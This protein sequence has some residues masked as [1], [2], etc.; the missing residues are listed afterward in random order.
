MGRHHFPDVTACGT[1]TAVSLPCMFSFLVQADYSREG[2]LSQETLL[3]VLVRAGFDLC[4]ADNNTGDQRIAARTGWTMVEASLDPLACAAECSDA[5][6]LPLI[7]Q[8][9]ASIDTDTV[10]VLHMISNHGPAYYLRYDKAHT[11]FRP[12]CRAARFA[13]CTVDEIV[14]AYGKAA[15][16][17]DHVLS[18][19][20]DLLA[21]SERV[22][23]AMVFLSDNGESLGENGLYLHAAPRFM[24]PDAQL[25]AR[26]VMWPGD[27]FRAASGLDAGCLH[28]VARRTA[29]HDNLFHTVLGL[30]DVEAGASNPALDL[31]Q[32]CRSGVTGCCAVSLKR[33][34]RPCPRA[35]VFYM[36]SMP[37]AIPTPGLSCASANAC[38]RRSAHEY[39]RA[40]CTVS[41]NV[42]SLAPT[43]WS[44]PSFPARRAGREWH[45]GSTGIAPV[46]PFIHD[47]RRGHRS[48]SVKMS[49]VP[50]CQYLAWMLE[51]VFGVLARPHRRRQARSSNRHETRG[52]R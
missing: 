17:T 15:L 46:S 41:I 29:S 26:L 16:E 43:E 14:N 10:L 9:L 6:F 35:T 51:D 52:R 24:A 3:D 22:L 25:K 38:Q 49:L 48:H 33:L 40:M 36:S 42:C 19:A 31:T 18:R 39:G 5:V 11:R 20:I 21:A 37:P 1:S 2:F 8:T 30:A 47:T 34:G 13:D 44:L 23:P 12:D 7:E 27:S 45:G 50:S 4:W 32:I 28:A